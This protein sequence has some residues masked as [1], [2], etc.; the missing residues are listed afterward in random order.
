MHESQSHL[1]VGVCGRERA[2][3]RINESNTENVINAFFYSPSCCI[4]SAVLTSCQ[5][6]GLLDNC[7]HFSLRADS[8]GLLFSNNTIFLSREYRHA[9]HTHTHAHT[10]MPT[11]KF[12]PTALSFHTHC[13]HPYMRR[14][15]HT[16]TVLKS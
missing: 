14:F 8:K 1:Y 7:V 15:K 5:G 13:S 16:L 4:I 12:S 2:R 9:H 3:V 10:L 11:H 6:L